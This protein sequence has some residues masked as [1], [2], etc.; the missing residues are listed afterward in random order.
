V[1]YSKLREF[2]NEFEQRV[3]I[4]CLKA[5]L[6]GRKTK[7]STG[8]G[9]LSEKRF[10]KVIGG[11]VDSDQVFAIDY[12]GHVKK[13]KGLLDKIKRL[14]PDEKQIETIVVYF[15]SVKVEHLVSVFCN[16]AFLSKFFLAKQD[17]LALRAFGDK[18][19]F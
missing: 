9:K 15:A 12:Y 5:G 10:G 3:V 2:L 16:S 19:R 7:I 4:K 1:D 11:I 6:L 8:N 13:S 14:K 17:I 18:E